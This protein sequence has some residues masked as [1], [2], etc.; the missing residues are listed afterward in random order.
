ML[1]FPTT[2]HPWVA[3][4]PRRLRTQRNVG[5]AKPD[6]LHAVGREEARPLSTENTLEKAAIGRPGH[7][8]NRRKKRTPIEHPL[9]FPLFFF[10]R[11]SNLHEF[12]RKKE[13]STIARFSFLYRLL[14]TRDTVK[15]GGNGEAVRG[16]RREKIIIGVKYLPRY[17]LD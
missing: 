14:D 3:A 6:L 9:P 12:P 2:Q 7:C 15:D 17:L 11:L 8:P 5:V 13:K 10:Y 4:V 1:R 16:T